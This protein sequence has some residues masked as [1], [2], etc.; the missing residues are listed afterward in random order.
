MQHATAARVV[1]HAIGAMLSTNRGPDGQA[2]Q[3]TV[4]VRDFDATSCSFDLHL[5]FVEGET[6]CCFESGCHFGFFDEAWFARLR[7]HL[8][9]DHP[10]LFRPLSVRR[11]NIAVPRGAKWLAPWAKSSS[12]ETDRPRSTVL[13]PFTESPD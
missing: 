4:V 1:E 9:S 11:V 13:G 8:P 6:Y 12:V 2:P 5:A 10:S 7:E 3:Y